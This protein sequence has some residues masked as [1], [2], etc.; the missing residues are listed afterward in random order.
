MDKLDLS[1]CVI[2]ESEEQKKPVKL[3]INDPVDSLELIS[4]RISPDT[5]RSLEALAKKY[6]VT[7]SEVMRQLVDQGIELVNRK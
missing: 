1:K 3:V 4:V 7:V 5:K 2:Q 6:K